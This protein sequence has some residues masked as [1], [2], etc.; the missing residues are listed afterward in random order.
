MALQWD[1]GGE[2][3]EHSEEAAEWVEE[4]RDE[5]NKHVLRTSAEEFSSLSGGYGNHHRNSYQSLAPTTGQSLGQVLS[6]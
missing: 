1:E 3:A 6:L 4:G 5:Y 2:R